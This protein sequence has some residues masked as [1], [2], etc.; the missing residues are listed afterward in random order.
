MP[1]HNHFWS[2]LFSP[3][4]FQATTINDVWFE[5]CV[6]SAVAAA[7]AIVTDK[8]NVNLELNN[9]MLTVIGT[10][11]GLVISFRTS[12]AYERCDHPFHSKSLYRD[13]LT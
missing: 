1:A 10:V 5:V 4:I 3:K 12:S 7:V 11:L 6:F 13:S 8:T 2:I 9:Q